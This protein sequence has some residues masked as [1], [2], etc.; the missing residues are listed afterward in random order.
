MELIKRLARFFGEGGCLLEPIEIP[1]T[2]GDRQVRRTIFHFPWP[3]ADGEPFHVLDNGSLVSAGAR[4]ADSV[5]IGFGVFIWNHTDIQDGVVLGDW[6]EVGTSTSI[7][8]HSTIEIGTCLDPEVQ[9]GRDC[10]IGQYSNLACGTRVP[11]NMETGRLVVMSEHFEV[12]PE[13]NPREGIVVIDEGTRVHVV[14]ARSRRAT[15]ESTPE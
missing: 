8:A 3:G 1:M 7:G 11:D 6:V 9:I 2:I 10:V 12:T 13:L 5:E 4:V 15:S 14:P